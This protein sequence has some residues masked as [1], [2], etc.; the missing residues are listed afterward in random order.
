M[1]SASGKNVYVCNTPSSFVVQHAASSATSPVQA[2]LPPPPS[3]PTPIVPLVPLVLEEPPV[4]AAPPA[5]APASLPL[6]AVLDLPAVDEAPALVA[7]DAVALQLFAAFH[8][9][10]P[11]IDLSRSSISIREPGH[12]DQA[13]KAVSAS[14]EN[15]GHAAKSEMQKCRNAA[16][17]LRRPCFEA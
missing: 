12:N 3:P 15:E 10:P 7:H 11:S 1:A 16:S 6:P 5:G 2:L 9:K 8:D 14:R 4:L 17:D 13:S